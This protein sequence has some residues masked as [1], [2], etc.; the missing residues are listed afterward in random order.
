MTQEVIDEASEHGKNENLSDGLIIGNDDINVDHSKFEHDG[1]EGV[2]GCA[3]QCNLNP[4]N[5][6]DNDHMNQMDDNNDSSHS[7]SEQEDKKFTQSL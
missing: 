2:C 6:N 4:Q 1:I 7:N 5:E 3:I